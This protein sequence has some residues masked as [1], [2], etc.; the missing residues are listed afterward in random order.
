LTNRLNALAR[1][2]GS[3]FFHQDILT[4]AVAASEELDSPTALKD[5][6]PERFSKLEKELVRGKG[7]VVSHF[8]WFISI[9]LTI[10]LQLKR[11]NQLGEVFTQIDWLYSELG[12]DPPPPT[13]TTPVATSSSTLAVPR[14]SLPR[15]S[16]AGSTHLNSSADPFAS[17][18]IGP[19]TPTPSSIGKSDNHMLCPSSSPPQPPTAL[20][21]VPEFPNER[22]YLRSLG[23]FIELLDSSPQ[24]SPPGP[25][26]N[27]CGIEP[28]QGIL[29]WAERLHAE[30]N[31][32]KR[33]REVH[34]QAMY[35]QLEALW[36]RMGVDEE[37]MDG[38]VEAN[39]GT[40]PP[41]V[42]AYEEELERMI[43]LK[44]ER[45][46]EF[47]AN[48]RTEIESLWEELMV[49]EV[50]RNDFAAFADG[51]LVSVTLLVVF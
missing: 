2:L 43:D 10:N 50:E 13:T 41:V 1:T 36:R 18:T 29:A 39:R 19:L 5:V 34:I 31:E 28:T 8:P 38:F 47:I 27:S 9:P 25:I 23:R 14:Y 15:S 37:A 46:G 40:T 7:E 49:G 35:D 48:A 24:D 12:I 22:E 26:L 44:R 51:E 32:L 33:R 30:L 3:H 6:M 4:P 20:P 42:Q 16:S 21:E 45:M 17:S 11:L